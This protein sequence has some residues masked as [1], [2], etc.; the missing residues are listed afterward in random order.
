MVI[1][2]APMANDAAR[3]LASRR[4]KKTPKKKRS[5]LL[6]EVVRKRWERYA[7]ENPEKWAKSEARRK[8]RAERGKSG[9]NGN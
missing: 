4:W 2:S 8:K 6:S 7:R 5:A 1:Y 3:E 9:N